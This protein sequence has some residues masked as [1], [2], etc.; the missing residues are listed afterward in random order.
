[1]RTSAGPTA[2]IDTTD[3]PQPSSTGGSGGG[4]PRHDLARDQLDL[5]PLVTQRPEVDSLAAGAGVTGQQL[6]ALL[7]RAYADLPAK[8]R[9]VS[10]DQRS[11][12]LRQDP[13]RL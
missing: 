10:P 13:F 2:P 11:D 1:M 3:G 5:P 7:R 4:D 12:N 8:L 9:R 6:G